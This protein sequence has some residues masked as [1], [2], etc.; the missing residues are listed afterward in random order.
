MESAQSKGAT[1]SNTPRPRRGIIFI[2]AA[3]SGAGKTTIWRGA[4]KA[5][6]RLEFSVS[7]TTRGPREGEADG[8]DYHF[9]SE[10]EFNRKVEGGELA[11]YDRHFDAS[12]G[13]LRAPL[14]A[15]VAAGR[16]ILLD[17]DVEGARQIRARYQRDAVAIFVLP[18]SFA[19][20][21]RRLR[22]RQTD[23][24]DAIQRRLKRATEEASEY[25]GYDYLIINHEVERSIHELAAIVNAERL[26]T[27]RLS[28]EVA[29]WKS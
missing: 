2:L 22:G 17:I 3:P 10:E 26:R 4:L 12:Y 16:D 1:T 5:I 19:D 25:P 15:A 6:A 20:L 14:E 29:P 7:L 23:T 27:S 21:E 18:P 11:E 9:V 24:E 28:G 8:F 13:T